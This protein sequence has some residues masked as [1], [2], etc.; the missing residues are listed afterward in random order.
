MSACISIYVCACNI[1]QLHGCQ[2]KDNVHLFPFIAL[3][4]LPVIIS[5]AIEPEFYI[6]T[7]ESSN[8]PGL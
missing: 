4:L 6:T 5:V 7:Y 3:P 8:N 1:Q 2:M